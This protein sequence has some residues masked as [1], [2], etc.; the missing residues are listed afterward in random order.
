M[1]VA[2]QK[3]LQELF[4]YHPDSGWF[5]NK[6]SR[7]RAKEGE[8][9]GHEMCHGYRRI[10]V[11]YVKHYEHHLAWLYMYGEY[12]TEIDHANGIRNDNRIVNLRLCN[13]SQN[14]FNTQTVTGISGL[15]GA[16]LDKRNRQWFSKIQFGGQQK[17]L[18]NFASA[19]EAHAAYLVA[20]NEIAGEFAYHNRPTQE[21]M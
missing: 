1:T 11:D 2:Q 21:A 10:I 3:E 18:G 4:V 6:C 13:R 7:G 8:R 9:A 17:F 20:L 15:T 5:T 12:P 16:Y 14:N 19:E